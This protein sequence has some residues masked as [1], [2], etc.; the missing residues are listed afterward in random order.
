MSHGMRTPRP[1]Q[2]AGLAAALCLLVAGHALAATTPRL[3]SPKCMPTAGDTN[4]TFT[5]L[6]SYY[7]ATEP[8][9]RDVRLDGRYLA[10]QKAGAGPNGSVI[11]TYKTKLAAG[12]HPYA[13]RF[14]VGTTT[15]YCPG[16]TASE[17]C[18]SPKVAAAPS[19]KIGGYIRVDKTGV[20]GVVVRLYG[21]GGITV[22][23][24]TKADGSY[25]ATALVPG[26]WTVCPRPED[27]VFSPASTKVTLPPDALRCSFAATPQ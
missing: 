24:T 10:M 17:F 9:S 18:T 2:L 26:T 22:S 6:I 5:F 14:K 3:G 11:Y 16:P 15:L 25:L 19:Q 20:A 21:P 12:T 27:Y 4:T 13:F 23:V 8:A 7:G 1:V